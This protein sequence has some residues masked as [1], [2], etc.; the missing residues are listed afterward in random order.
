MSDERWT[1]AD[2]ASAMFEAIPDDH[3]VKLTEAFA[4]ALAALGDDRAEAFLAFIVTPESREAWGDFSA[5]AAALA[6]DYG[7]NS[8][9]RS[10]PSAPDV[11]YVYLMEHEPKARMIT[12]PEAVSVPHTFTWVWR[13]ELGGWRL[14]GIG[15]GDPPELLPRTSPHSAP[16]INAIAPH[17]P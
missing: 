12:R 1:D 3:P 14:H 15:P 2:D 9:A 10:W 8:V 17:H 6:G 13:P 11:A 16:D 5:A 4:L 7:I